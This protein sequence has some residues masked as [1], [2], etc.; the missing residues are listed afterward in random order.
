[1]M[2]FFG[3]PDFSWMTLKT[4]DSFG[5]FYLWTNR[6]IVA[7][8]YIKYEELISSL[9]VS[10]S[11]KRSFIRK[12]HYGYDSWRMDVLNGLCAVFDA[13]G[14]FCHPVSF[15]VFWCMDGIGP[16]QSWLWLQ[17]ASSL[18]LELRVGR[19]DCSSEWWFF[20][21]KEHGEE[22][23]SFFHSFTHSRTPAINGEEGLSWTLFSDG[24]DLHNPTL[25]IWI[26][27]LLWKKQGIG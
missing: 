4:S 22:Q 23:H 2:V 3:Q 19:D 14:A 12:S 24:Y 17:R 25:G 7:I 27:L 26:L 1:M 16:Y 15:N 8:L 13:N 6:G 18:A 10:T 11:P 21:L 5:I 9:E 20:P